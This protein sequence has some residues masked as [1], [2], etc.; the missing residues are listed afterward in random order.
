MSVSRRNLMAALLA[1]TG[2]ATLGELGCSGG[3][4]P[5]EPENIDPLMDTLSATAAAAKIGARWI[6]AEFYDNDPKP[7]ELL[8]SIFD[9]APPTA[10]DFDAANVRELIATKIRADFSERR[11]TWLDNWLL[12]N[13]ELQVYGYVALMR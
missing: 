2:L 1:G 8:Q 9:G 10:E 7:E 4:R 11:T 3:C 6:D 12:S 5:S 13:T